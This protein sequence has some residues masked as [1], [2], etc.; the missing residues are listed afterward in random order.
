[1]SNQSTQSDTPETDAACDS[2]NYCDGNFARK[3]ERER[4]Q[5]RA[6]VAELTDEISQQANGYTA[7]INDLN[8]QLAELER[9]RERLDWLEKT[10]CAEY[11]E[12]LCCR[13]IN[14]DSNTDRETIR[15]AIDA[16]KESKQ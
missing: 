4:D 8:E 12:G 3:L 5:L 15:A 14:M 9:D 6:R 10:K 16:A 13:R 2:C 7:T 1:M 11:M